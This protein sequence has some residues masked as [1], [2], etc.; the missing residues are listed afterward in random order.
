MGNLAI[1]VLNL[2]SNIICLITLL[3]RVVGELSWEIPV[4]QLNEPVREVS[5]TDWNLGDE[6]RDGITF[7]DGHSVSDTLASIEHSTSCATGGEQ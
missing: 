4:Q 3:L 5:A 6:V 2:D 1:H 7:V